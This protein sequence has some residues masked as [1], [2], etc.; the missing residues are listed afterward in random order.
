MLHFV[1]FK[2]EKWQMCWH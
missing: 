1:A 2:D